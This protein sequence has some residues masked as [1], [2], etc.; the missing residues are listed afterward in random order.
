MQCQY[1]QCII[2][3]HVCIYIY[4]YNKLVYIS[5][6]Y[7]DYTDQYVS[8]GYPHQ[9]HEIVFYWLLPFSAPPPQ[10]RSSVNLPLSLAPPPF[11]T[12]GPHAGRRER[13]D[14]WERR[15]LPSLL[16]T[17]PAGGYKSATPGA[18]RVQCV[19]RRRRELWWLKAEDRGAEKT[20]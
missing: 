6:I 11:F 8:G 7:R 13:A 3:G 14:Q 18:R 16:P 1:I 20:R 10:L 17:L 4:I 2:I 19:R 12:I 9:D 15:W 5:D